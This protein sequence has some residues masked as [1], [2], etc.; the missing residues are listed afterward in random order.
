[1]ISL[2]F[3]DLDLAVAVNFRI[4][5]VH[6]YTLLLAAPCRRKDEVRYTFEGQSLGPWRS[7]R[8]EVRDFPGAVHPGRGGLWQSRQMCQ[9]WEHYTHCYQSN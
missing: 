2:V 7:P 8:I 6:V 3:V 5:P 1:M 4:I 9:S